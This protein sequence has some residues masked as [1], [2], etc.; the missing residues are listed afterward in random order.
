MIHF[1]YPDVDTEEEQFSGCGRYAVSET[2]PEGYDLPF[3]KILNRSKVSDAALILAKD[4]SDKE[5][6]DQVIQKKGEKYIGESLHLAYLF[7]LIHRSREVKLNI[8]TDIWT[9]GS[10]EVSDGKPFLKSVKH[11]GFQ[12][13]LEKGFLSEENEDMLFIVPEED[14]QPEHED[15]CSKNNAEI[16]SF[17]A[18]RDCLSKDKEIFQKKIIVKVRED[19]LFALVSLVFE[20]GPNPYKGLEYFD[21]EDADRFFG[22]ED[23]TEK[24]FEKYQTLQDSPIRLMAILGPS[25]SGKSSIA[26]AGLIHK[27]RHSADHQ[28]IVFRPGEYPLKAFTEELAKNN[29]SDPDVILVDQFEEI[30]TQCKD[31]A[32]RNQF[33]RNLLHASSDED[34]R[35]SVIIILRTD[36]LKQTKNHHP[37][38]YNAIAENEIIVKAMTRNQIRSLI[39]EPAR[40]SGYIFDTETVDRLI[41]ETEKH[42]GALPLL[43]F[44]LDSIWKGMKEGGVQPAD[45]LEKLNGVGGALAS[46]AQEIYDGLASDT[47][48][49]IARRAFI[50]LIN[51][52]E[53]AFDTRQR[54][55]LSQ[56]VAKD[57]S[58]EH[59]RN[60][61]QQFS[62]TGKAYFIILSTDAEGKET[63]EITHEAL[64]EHWG[65]LKQ[66]LDE[67][68][69]DLPFIHRLEKASSH[70]KNQDKPDG[71]LWRTPDLESLKGYHERNKQD[72]TEL[73]HDFFEA[74]EKKREEIEEKEKRTQRFRR[75]A[76]KGL[77]IGSVVLAMMAIFAFF[78]RDVALKN[79][80]IARESEKIAK[81]ERDEADKQRANA[82]I[83]AAAL[84]S[85]NLFV[86]DKKFDA[87]IEAIR[88]GRKLQQASVEIKPDIKNQVKIVLQQ[89]VYGIR[90]RNRI[91]GELVSGNINSDVIFSPNGQ[92]FASGAGDF[93]KLWSYD[94]TLYKAINVRQDG[95][96][97]TFEKG[98]AF[99]PDGRKIVFPFRFEKL[100]QKNGIFKVSHVIKIYDIDTAELLNV[101]DGHDGMIDGLKFSHDGKIIASSSRD[102][103]VKL[104][105]FDKGLMVTLEHPNVIIDDICFVDK[106]TI[107]TVYGSTLKFWDFNANLIKKVDGPKGESPISRFSPNGNIIASVMKSDV[108]LWNSDGKELVSIKNGN[109]GYMTNVNFSP[110]NKM[111]ALIDIYGAI[112]LWNCNGT[113]IETLGKHDTTFGKVSFSPDGETLVSTGS[114]ADIKIWNIKS[115]EPKTF[116]FRT[117]GISFSPNSNTIAMANN[118]TVKLYNPDGSLIR[119]IEHEKNVVDVNF[120]PDGKLLTSDSKPLFSANYQPKRQKNP[121]TGIKIWDTD[122]NLL[123]TIDVRDPYINIPYIDI[124]RQGLYGASGVSFSPEG[125]VIVSSDWNGILRFW[126]LDGIYG[127]ILRL[128]RISKRPLFDIAYSSDAN[129]IAVAAYA[130]QI[131]LLHKNEP[132]PKILKGHKDQIHCISFSPDGQI[133]ASASLDC[134]V[135]IWNLQG[136]ELK[137][138][139]HDAAVISVSFSPDSETILTAGIDALKLWNLSGDQINQFGGTTEVRPV[140]YRC[141]KFSPDGNVIVAANEENTI[142]LWSYD[143]LQ[144]FKALK[145]HS[146]PIRDMSFSPD[147]KILAS[148]SADKTAKIWNLA[149]GKEIATLRHN[150]QV[151]G[152]N[153]SPDGQMLASACQDSIVRVWKTDGELLK[154]LLGKINNPNS[155]ISGA[156]SI[157]TSPNA[158]N[159]VSSNYYEVQL[160][161]INGELL[162]VFGSKY[163]KAWFD[164]DGNVM[165]SGGVGETGSYERVIF[166]PDGKMIASTCTTMDKDM[167][168]LWS[169]DSSE[170]K[171]LDGHTSEVN[172]IAFS[173]NGEILASAGLDRTVRLWGIDG[174]QQKILRGHNGS[175]RS[176]SF[177]RDALLA[178]AGE[179]SIKL[180]NRNGALLK[181]IKSGLP[182]KLDK[183]K[184]LIFS[185]DGKILASVRDNNITFWSFDLDE[186]LACGCDWL[187]D[188]LKDENNDTQKS[189]YL[190]EGTEFLGSLSVNQGKNL[191]LRGDVEGAILKFKKS[192]QQNPKLDFD[193]KEKA[194]ELATSFLISEGEKLA[195]ANDVKGAIKNFKKAI[196]WNSSLNFDPEKK[197]QK[198]ADKYLK[199]DKDQDIISSPMDFEEPLRDAILK[200]KDPFSSILGKLIEQGEFDFDEAIEVFKVIAVALSEQGKLDEALEHL[201]N[202]PTKNEDEKLRLLLIKAQLLFDHER[203]DEAIEIY[204]QAFEQHPDKIYLLGITADA[205]WKQGKLNEAEE[206]FAKGLTVQPNNLVLLSNDAELALVQGDIARCQKRIE[207]ALPLLTP[208]DQTFAIIPFISWLSSSE[209]GWEKVMTAIVDLNPEV[210]FTWDFSTMQPTIERLDESTRQTAQHF[211]AFFENR[212]DFPTLKSKLAEKR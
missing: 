34:S 84:S 191:A 109:N 91:E 186:L 167:I 57:E 129:T 19:E 21:E 65:S 77:A 121:K 45:T 82:E 80:K 70:W 46:R 183:W 142:E 193:P 212:M 153:F 187:Y 95:F 98:M 27:I 7:A 16:L 87:L 148:A 6:K 211:I 103:T 125:K 158:E 154:P 120:S 206:T 124:K 55:L 8:L 17:E 104:W 13:K 58:S 63:A 119:I 116:P 101:F 141:A 39:T 159:L 11:E 79:E 114:N 59:V 14:I 134:S 67:K 9:T 173:P 47:D 181:T 5:I 85:E 29:P 180:W 140:V 165:S 164:S 4:S 166:S 53:G 150:D 172:D 74:S 106:Q 177:S 115:F 28:D 24:L 145:G 136:K 207:T 102:H 146:S 155:T 174:K 94:G 108:K 118:K 171:I 68:R 10:I 132:V 30:Y 130:G 75:N 205:L 88:A 83:Q 56:I 147:G 204:N 31:E 143:G 157:S 49:R 151:L 152:V 162:K 176:I 202:V 60:V 86:S 37:E 41:S 92:L 81:Q 149:D 188:Y 38:L 200:G 96:I 100:R 160:R 128:L 208:K 26:R 182:I 50:S 113:L 199:K 69:D 156:Y 161:N 62:K 99:S 2:V 23:V 3:A 201:H 40:R 105:E 209:Q 144:M 48:R 36:F 25:G 52:G 194:Q 122:G 54:V 139:K 123:K 168:K 43:E 32:E 12:L 135:K 110:D 44:A 178:S 35:V 42:E 192:L 126:S 71:L 51:I 179:D 112:S 107:C 90:E 189:R 93:I 137:E 197:A 97:N 89:A 78:Q 22:R 72:M 33:V 184:K 64:F 133:F 131:I 18:F 190:C 127:T 15:L 210:A 169:L 170:E 203:Y 196:K 61:L 1:A 66:W 117:K 76:F 73:Q 185:P 163:D 198:I 111:I 20:L 195:K 175:V 138:L